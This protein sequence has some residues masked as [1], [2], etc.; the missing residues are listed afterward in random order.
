MHGSSI[1]LIAFFTSILT[2][3]GTVYVIERLH[4]LEPAQEALSEVPDVQG[5]SEA[6]A[7]ENLRAHKLSLVIKARVASAQGKPGTVIGQSVP[8][9]QKVPENHPIAVTLAEEPPK[10]PS[11][12]GLTVAEATAQLEKQGYK[13]TL[14][15]LAVDPNVPEGRIISQAP[16]PDGA[17]EKGGGV[18]VQVSA[19][20]G[21]VE[22]PKVV[23]KSV[24]DAKQ[25]IEKAALKLSPV[26]WVSVA[27][28]A[29]Y[30]VLS[31]KP[32]AGEKVKPG[33]TIELTANR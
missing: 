16:P 18:V 21:E 25:L 4:L 31:Q 10:V 15:E 6:D 7:R 12:I 30:V 32:P 5:L 22:V 28:T 14:G 2:A 33:D 19:G 8:A 26:R 3:T 11:V 24:N 20:V 27:E 17:L 23:G 29:T 13:L 9:G 1:F